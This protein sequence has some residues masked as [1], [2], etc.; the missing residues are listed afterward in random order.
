MVNC[1]LIVSHGRCG[2][3]AVEWLALDGNKLTGSIP[4][5]VSMVTSLGR[6]PF[7]SSCAV[8]SL[9]ETCYS[10]RHL[11]FPPYISLRNR[12][13]QTSY[14]CTVTISLDPFRVPTLLDGARSRATMGPTKIVECSNRRLE[15]ESFDDAFKTVRIHTLSHHTKHVIKLLVNRMYFFHIVVTFDQELSR[16]RGSSTQL[17]LRR[18]R[19]DRNLLEE[20]QEGLFFIIP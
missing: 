17:G 10:L 6:L 19:F 4:S 20:G 3:L 16:F 7:P 14:G 9:V 8:Y 13:M 15:E 11:T 18:K 1:T 5:E 2:A 12:N